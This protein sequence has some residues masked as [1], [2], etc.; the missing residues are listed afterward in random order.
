[1]THYGQ[2][3]SLVLCDARPVTPYFCG[4]SANDSRGSVRVR[5]RYYP[6]FAANEI[7]E[8]RD[9]KREIKRERDFVGDSRIVSAKLGQSAITKPD[10]HIG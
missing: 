9:L 1:M 5:E 8:R 6:C 4:E 2:S 10:W 7:G 3:A